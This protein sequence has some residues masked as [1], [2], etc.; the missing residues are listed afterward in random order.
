MSWDRRRRRGAGGLAVAAVALA[1][2]L[3]GSACSSTKL[4]AL[5]KDPRHRAPAFRKI[6]VIGFTLSPA[7]RRDFEAAI[8][9]RLERRRGVTAVMSSKLIPREDALNR[10]KIEAAIRGSGIDGVLVTR[11]ISSKVRLSLTPG[12]AFARP[13]NY[14]SFYNFYSAAY[15]AVLSPTH[16]QS[17]DKLRLETTVYDAKHG[18]LRWM[19]V[20]ETVDSGD[21]DRGFYNDFAKAIMNGMSA[22]GLL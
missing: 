2:A 19:A 17:M 14:G 16:L 9:N 15:R 13:T 3:T 10:K 4:I 12:G 11:V 21:S 8:A 5:W 20:T 6:L 1:A 18:K 7:N 22:D